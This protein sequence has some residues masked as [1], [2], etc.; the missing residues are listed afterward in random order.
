MRCTYFD[1]I[2][3]LQTRWRVYYLFTNTIIYNVVIYILFFVENVLKSVP[4]K[5]VKERGQNLK[6]F[7]KSFQGST[8]PK[9]PRPDFSKVSGLVA[10]KEDKPTSLI[11]RHVSTFNT[12]ICL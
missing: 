5:L 4:G 6:G 2:H 11:G 8:I 1:C 12:F 3:I 10:E 9:T 7:L